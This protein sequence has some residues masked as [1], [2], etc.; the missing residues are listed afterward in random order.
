MT[1]VEIV[2]PLLAGGVVAEIT[3]INPPGTAYKLFAPKNKNGDHAFVCTLSAQRFSAVADILEQMPYI[4]QHTERDIQYK[5]YRLKPYEPAELG[6]TPEIE[7]SPI[8]ERVVEEEELPV[9]ISA[10]PSVEAIEIPT[11][12][13]VP[14]EPVQENTPKK[15]MSPANFVSNPLSSPDNLKNTHQRLRAY[16]NG[17]YQPSPSRLYLD[18]WAA[19]RAGAIISEL[20]FPTPESRASTPFANEHGNQYSLITKPTSGKNWLLCRLD[21]KI[22][23][24]LLNHGLIMK[25]PIAGRHFKGTEYHYYRLNNAEYTTVVP[26]SGVTIHKVHDDKI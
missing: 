21:S 19:L 3:Y 25:L 11:D 6:K 8:A 26:P 7:V 5:W 24:Q 15:N 23:K 1:F 2:K 9:E 18:I 14:K 12:A 4:G 17:T 22:F 13:E 16:G 20:T 10:E